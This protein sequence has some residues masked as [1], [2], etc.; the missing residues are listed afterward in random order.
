MQMNMLDRW[1]LKRPGL[2]YLF[3]KIGL[4]SAQTQTTES[5]SEC[6]KRLATGKLRIVEIGVW[7]GVNTRI[8]ANAMS[9]S[10]I[11]YAC[12][13]FFPGKLGFCWYREI[14]HHEARRDRSKNV[15]FLEMKSSEAAEQFR[16]T[17]EE[18]FDL[19]F[20]DGDHSYKGVS[21]DWSLFAPLVA[22]GGHIALHDSRSHPGRDI[23]HTD[24]VKFTNDVPRKSNEFA[25][26]EEVDSLTVFRA[27]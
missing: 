10:G 18:D 23:D 21:E 13:P 12:D 2:H 26:A 11:L 14:A 3:W 15:Q 9:E 20:I 5:E 7:H 4:A 25:V 1:T 6:L 17:G 16:K 24:V 8:L 27:L 22:T 19:I